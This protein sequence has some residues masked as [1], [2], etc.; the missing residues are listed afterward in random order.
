MKEKYLDVLKR[1]SAYQKEHN[2]HQGS[3][4]N[5]SGLVDMAAAIKE[6]AKAIGSKPNKSGLERLPVPSWDGNRRSYGT[7]KKEF[8]HWMTLDRARQSV[9]SGRSSTSSSRTNENSWMS[10]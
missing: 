6:M 5:S 3:S 8:E 2:N 10:L 1:Y 4:N 7:W 9:R